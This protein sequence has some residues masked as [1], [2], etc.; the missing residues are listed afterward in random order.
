VEACDLADCGHL[1]KTRSSA[2]Q[3]LAWSQ[4]GS[5]RGL[6]SGFTPDPQVSEWNS[7]T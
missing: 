3:M 5:L 2:I 7:A 6:A 4:G 1:G